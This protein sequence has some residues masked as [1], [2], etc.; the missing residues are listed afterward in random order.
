MWILVRLSLYYVMQKETE[1]FRIMLL[2]FS[3]NHQERTSWGQPTSPRL[4]DQVSIVCRRRHLSPRTEDS[5]RYWVRQFIYYQ[6]KRHPNTMGGPEV[7]ALRP[8]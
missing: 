6:E 4:L 5:Y 3:L 7:E 8:Q 2:I 1:D